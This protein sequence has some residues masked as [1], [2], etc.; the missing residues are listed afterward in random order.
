VA[1]GNLTV[2]EL[3]DGRINFDSAA[4][5]RAQSGGSAERGP[6]AGPLPVSRRRSHFGIKFDPAPL[7]N[8]VFVLEF[9]KFLLVAWMQSSQVSTGI[10]NHWKIQAKYFVGYLLPRPLTSGLDAPCYSFLVA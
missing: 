3:F 8:L 6:L 1:F 9:L 2:G 5:A 4:R 7:G 10:N